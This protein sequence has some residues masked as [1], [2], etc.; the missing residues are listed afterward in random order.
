MLSIQKGTMTM[1]KRLLFFFAPAVY[2]A[3]ILLFAQNCFCQLFP[4]PFLPPPGDIIRG[5]EQF[6]I[7]DE[8]STQISWSG[9]SVFSATFDETYPDGGAFTGHEAIF[10]VPE[11]K[12][13]S[14]VHVTQKGDKIQVLITLLDGTVYTND[15]N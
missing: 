1:R 11:G 3:H 4:N 2:A 9:N 5:K 13:I 10:K 8:G 15:F 7:H 12:D 6:Y 14:D